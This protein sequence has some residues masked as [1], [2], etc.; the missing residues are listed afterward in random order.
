MSKQK[1]YLAQ[2]LQKNHDAELPPRSNPRALRRRVWFNKHMRIRLRHGFSIVEVMTVIA[3]IGIVAGLSI[4]SLGSWQRT[5]A[6]NTVKSDMHQAYG[7]LQNHKNFK[8]NYPPNMAGTS[9]ANSDNVALRLLTN[10]PS[11]GVYENLESDQNAQLFLNSCNASLFM[12]PYST[13]CSFQ[14]NNEGAK[15]HAKGTNGSNTIWGSPIAQS[16]LSISCP[17][18]QQACDDAVASMISQF[19]AQGGQFPIIVP[20]KNVPLPEPTLIPNGPAN[21]FCL[22]GRASQYP[23][24]VFYVHSDGGSLTPGECPNDPS[25]NYYL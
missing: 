5:Q 13:A 22:E 18:Q 8:N 4:L 16:E 17:S 19:L 11:V 3:V 15:I 25:L 1:S 9:Y 7:A 10:A 6:T 12:A 23:D 2:H 20:D 24:I 21:R 14:G